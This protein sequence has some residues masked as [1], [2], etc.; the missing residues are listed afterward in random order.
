MF[1]FLKYIPFSKKLYS[2][3]LLFFELNVFYA[4]PMLMYLIKA[5]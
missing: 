3:Y 4:K 5:A 1:P 2:V